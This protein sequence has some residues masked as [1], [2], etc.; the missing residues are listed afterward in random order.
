MAKSSWTTQWR[1]LTFNRHY[2]PANSSI[3]ISTKDQ[4]VCSCK[5][6]L[7]VPLQHIN[8]SLRN[9]LIRS[10]IVDKI[11]RLNLHCVNVETFPILE[12]SFS[13]HLIL[14][15][16]WKNLKNLTSINYSSLLKLLSQP[17]NP[18]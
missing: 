5:Y 3:F 15:A 11:V 18:P 8:V 7:S 10:A 16:C 14:W 6:A 1:N 12:H 2:P 9:L 17:S 13:E 4:T